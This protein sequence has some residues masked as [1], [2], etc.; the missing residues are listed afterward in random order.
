MRLA[1]EGAPVK[2]LPEQE[3]FALLTGRRPE[4]IVGQFTL[5]ELARLT[6]VPG[7]RLRAWLRRGWVEPAEVRDGVPWF[8]YDQL[9]RIRSL[10]R[11]VDEGVSIRRIGRSLAN[12][13]SWLP[14]AELAL[15][16]L[17]DISRQRRLSTRMGDGRLAEPQGQ[18]LFE[19]EP[20]RAVPAEDRPAV[21][22]PMPKTA[23]GEAAARPTTESV[24]DSELWEA[25]LAAEREG[26][27]EEAAEVY[28]ELLDRQPTAD[29]WFNLGNCFFALGRLESASDAYR[30]ALS[31]APAFIEAWNNLGAT[32][33]DLAQWPEAEDALRRALRLAPAYADAHYNLADLLAAQG[34]RGESRRHRREFR[35]AQTSA[36]K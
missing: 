33:M 29:L 15:W 13:R 20:S 6:G 27:F 28:R 4:A 14:G 3:F 9:G 7:Q 1:R 18:L 17:A 32:L 23:A 25:A 30:Q 19:F 26:S 22:F 24:T 21:L 34:R 11:L 36:L 35:K 10:S 31:I 8:G 12:L 5:G 2:I 16:Q